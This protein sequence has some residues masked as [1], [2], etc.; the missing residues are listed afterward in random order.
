M[1]NDSLKAAT[2]KVKG[3][4]KVLDMELLKHHEEVDEDS[5]KKDSFGTSGEFYGVK[6]LLHSVMMTTNLKCLMMHAYAFQEG[7]GKLRVKKDCHSKDCFRL[8]V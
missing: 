5:W 8:P 7:L 6:L 3:C 4:K 1:D 2:S